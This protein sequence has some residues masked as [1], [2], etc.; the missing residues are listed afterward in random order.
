MVK[1]F[2]NK[3]FTPPPD[4][5]I[6]DN[7]ERIGAESVDAFCSRGISLM[8][9]GRVRE[10]G[11]EL[12]KVLTGQLVDDCKGLYSM[13]HDNAAANPRLSYDHPETIRLAYVFVFIHG[14]CTWC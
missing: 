10:A 5:L 1:P 12:I 13:F 11:Q 14:S 3:P 6:A 7:F 2:K 9:E 8:D 4:N